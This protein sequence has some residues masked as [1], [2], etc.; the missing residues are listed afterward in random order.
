MPHCTIRL[1]LLLAICMMTNGCRRESISEPKRHYVIGFSQCTNDLWRQIMMI[2]MQA[3]AAKYPE[4]SIVVSNA[5]N[6]TQLQID[7]IREFI[8]A[9]VDLLIISPNESEPVTPIAVEAFDMGIPTIIWDRKIHSDHYTTCISADNYDIGR[10]VG[11]YINTILSEGSTILEI[12]GLMSSSPAVERHKGFLAEASES[13]SVHT[14]PGDWKPDVAKERVAAIGHYNDIDLV[15]A[16]NDDMALAAY[17]VINAADSLCAQRIKF[18][19]IDAL[20]GVDAVLDGRLQASFLYPTG[21]D[22]VMAIARR[23]LLGKR[24]EK[25]YQLQSALVDSHNA[26]TLK[27]QQEQIVSYQEQINKQKTVLEQYDRSVDNLKYSLWAVIIIALVA[28]GM[29]I[30]AI[31]LNLRLRRRNEILTAKNAEIE[32]ATRELMDKHAQ[33]ENVTAHKLQF[34]TNITH[35][36]RTPLTLI[37]NPL[38]SIV[39]RE[40][41]PEIQRNIWT[42]QRNAR[43]LLNVVNQ[44][45]DFRRSKIIK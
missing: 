10:D 25:S 32:I 15:F 2:Q 13:Y 35:E 21:G 11:R 7:Q 3:E 5:H 16:H 40:K 18:I 9:K 42:I 45:L 33:I 17:N 31:R 43:H 23:I 37:L 4:L 44:I 6:N 29:G 12:T 41:D 36:I 28:G 30:Y 8:E 1:F 19:G 39:K 20:V 38:D 34:F 22:K 24:V 14:I 26:Y 27:A